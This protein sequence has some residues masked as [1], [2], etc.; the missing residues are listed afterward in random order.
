MI[1]NLRANLTI[2]RKGRKGR[3]ED[4]FFSAAFAAFAFNR[5]VDYSDT[6]LGHEPVRDDSERLLE[7]DRITINP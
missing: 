6:L 5:G 7:R 2:E 1:L 4:S 3:K